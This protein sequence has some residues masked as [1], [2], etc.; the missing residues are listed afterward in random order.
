MRLSV[1][2]NKQLQKVKFYVVHGIEYGIISF[3]LLTQLGAV[4]DCG[5]KTVKIGNTIIG[6][7]GSTIAATSVKT[8]KVCRVQLSE[9]TVIH[10]GQERFLS[11]SIDGVEKSPFEGVVEAV[12]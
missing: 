4:I 2:R 11:A 12:P 7:A 9:S 6:N 3:P 8:A 5:L 10:P 1:G